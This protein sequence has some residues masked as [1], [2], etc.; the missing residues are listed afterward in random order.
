MGSRVYANKTDDAEQPST[1]LLQMDAEAV[2]KDFNLKLTVLDIIEEGHKAAAVA[3]F[4][5]VIVGVVLGLSLPIDPNIPGDLNGILAPRPHWSSFCAFTYSDWMFRE[6]PV[7]YMPQNASCCLRLEWT[8]MHPYT[9]WTLIAK[10]HCLQAYVGNAVAFIAERYA[11]AS[12]ILGW[13]YFGCW[14]IGW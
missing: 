10:H 13:T 4:S 14:W 12:N 11:H 7:G 5:A 3:I 1:S 8:A 2:R 6:Q 9:A